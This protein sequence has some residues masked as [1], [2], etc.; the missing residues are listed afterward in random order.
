VV[1]VTI[2]RETSPWKPLPSGYA[3]AEIRETTAGDSGATAD[4]A[5]TIRRNARYVSGLLEPDRAWQER[6]LIRD[7]G[8]NRQAA[9]NDGS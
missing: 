5:G 7:L 9:A 6:A 3:E 8:Q 4:D 2:L 1:L